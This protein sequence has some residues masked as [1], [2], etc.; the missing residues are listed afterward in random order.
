MIVEIGHYALTL[1]LALALAQ[2]IVPLWG[3]MR[4]D[5]GLI[6]VAQ[7]TAIGQFAAIALSFAS[8]VEAHLVSDFSVLNV[9]ENSHTAVPTIYKITG[10]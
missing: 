10:V 3:A 4:R 7:S 8:L 1:A 6:G 5:E 9:A 2:A